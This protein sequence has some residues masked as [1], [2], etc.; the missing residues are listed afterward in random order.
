MPPMAPGE[1]PIGSE[2]AS[3]LVLTCGINSQMLFILPYLESLSSK[4]FC[5]CEY[6]YMYIY[7]ILLEYDIFFFFDIILAYIVQLES[8]FVA[9]L[10]SYYDVLSARINN[11]V[12]QLT[13]AHITLKVRLL[14]KLAFIAELQQNLTTACK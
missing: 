14:F 7:R 10:Q 9:I 12:A 5:S 13:S 1:D 3:S 4:F 6:I 11:H 8:A 2:R